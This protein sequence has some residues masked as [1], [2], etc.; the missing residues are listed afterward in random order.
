MLLND[1]HSGLNDSST[2]YLPPYCE[3]LRVCPLPPFHV[4]I[5]RQLELRRRTPVR[6][7]EATELS[8]TTS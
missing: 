8:L 5:R 6:N 1:G 3:S 7:I 2:L 4:P